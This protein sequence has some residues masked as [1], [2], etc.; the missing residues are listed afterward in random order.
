MAVEEDV[1]ALVGVEEELGQLAVVAQQ[2]AAEEGVG[3]VG[4]LVVP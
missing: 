3:Y 2:L 1:Q 4:Y